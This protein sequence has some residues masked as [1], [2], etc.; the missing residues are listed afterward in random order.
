M[1]RAVRGLGGAAPS[2]RTAV[3]CEAHYP[4]N[5]LHAVGLDFSKRF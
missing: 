4:P 5:F 2:T 3:P 1:S